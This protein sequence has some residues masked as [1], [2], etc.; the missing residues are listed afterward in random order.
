MITERQLRYLGHA[1]RYPDERWVKFMHEAE[2]YGGQRTGKQ[3]QYC[4]L[5]T[6]LMKQYG[7]NKE[8]MQDRESWRQ[9]LDELFPRGTV[10]TEGKEEEENPSGE[11]EEK[12]EKSDTD[13][14]STLEEQSQ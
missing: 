1:Q 3:K 2:T 9:K 10:L 5:I 12:E 14:N 4:K 11:K 13:T 7:L 8:C 6:G